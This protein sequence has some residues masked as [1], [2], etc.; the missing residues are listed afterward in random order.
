MSLA[1]IGHMKNLPVSV[2]YICMH[3]VCQTSSSIQQ[4]G[5]VF[6]CNMQ[7][8]RM[9]AAHNLRIVQPQSW[10]LSE[11]AHA[12]AGHTHTACTCTVHVQRHTGT[13]GTHC[14]DCLTRLYWV[15]MHLH[16]QS[17]IV[18]LLPG[19]FRGRHHRPRGCYNAVTGPQAWAE[20]S[21]VHI[22]T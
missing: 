1:C 12:W 10:R 4:S 6:L 15:P 18:P 5:C 20:T 11:F 17:G 19:T 8:V 21:S 16:V 13:A 7:D 2:C 22:H 14:N 9:L 3:S